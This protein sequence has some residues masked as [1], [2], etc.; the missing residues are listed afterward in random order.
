MWR[1]GRLVGELLQ[2]GINHDVHDVESAIQHVV[3]RTV[4]DQFKHQTLM[5]SFFYHSHR[6]TC[7]ISNMFAWWLFIEVYRTDYL[8]RWVQKN[9]FALWMTRFER[10][11]GQIVCGDH[12]F[13]C[14]KFHRSSVSNLS[15]R[16]LTDTVR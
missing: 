7:S 3:T 5:S 16:Q 14:H 2:G 6:S 10:R 4:V 8:L 15:K 13:V 9:N 11:T 12:C 1:F